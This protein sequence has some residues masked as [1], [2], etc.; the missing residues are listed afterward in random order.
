MFQ[1]HSKFIQLYIYTCSFQVIF[2]YRLFQG[3]LTIVP[4]VSR[5]V[6]SNPV[7]PWTGTQCPH[8]YYTEIFVSC[9]LFFKLEI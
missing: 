5:S 7:T 1:V 2:H 3:I 4:C 8:L 6:V 9:C